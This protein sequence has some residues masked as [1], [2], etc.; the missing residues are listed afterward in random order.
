MGSLHLDVDVAAITLD[1]EF[2]A[3]L[4]F[5]RRPRLKLKATVA[6]Q[7]PR[8]KAFAYRGKEVGVVNASESGAQVS[9]VLAIEK[10]DRKRGCKVSLPCCL[11]R[12]QFPIR[13]PRIEAPSAKDR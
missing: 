10:T 11:K 7:V 13:R 9:P 12:P 6:G 8:G 3:T 4:P 1:R 5:A 2:E